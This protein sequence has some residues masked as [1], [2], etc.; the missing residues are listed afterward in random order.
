MRKALVS[1][2]FSSTPGWTRT[3][4]LA[5]LASRTLRASL[6]HWIPNSIRPAGLEPATLGLEI[7]CSIQLSYGREHSHDVLT[8]GGENRK[9]TA[10]NC[11]DTPHDVDSVGDRAGHSLQVR[12]GGSD[13][14]C[15]R[16]E[17]RPRLSVRTDV[18]GR[19]NGVG[20]TLADW[21]CRMRWHRRRDSHAEGG[22]VRQAISRVPRTAAVRISASWGFLRRAEWPVNKMF[23]ERLCRE[24]SP[25]ISRRKPRRWKSFLVC[26]V[27]PPTGQA[28]ESGS[29]AFMADPLIDHHS[30]K[31]RP[32]M[33]DNG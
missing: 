28:D 3:S 33:R 6:R 17:T 15:N 24:K 14:G 26:A 25:G 22:T 16:P 5:F 32:S 11:L 29:M 10:W 4:G 1:Q 13:R 19:S 21:V 8:G 2:C 7:P 27:R 20:R 23:V 12:R 30:I 18:A 31:S 9:G